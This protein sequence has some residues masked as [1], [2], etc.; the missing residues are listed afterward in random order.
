MRN[1]RIQ[2]AAA[3]N[4]S[5]VLGLNFEL[6]LRSGTMQLPAGDPPVD[7]RQRRPEQGTPQDARAAT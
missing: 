4:L 5:C 7:T 2:S 3:T 6:K 1:F